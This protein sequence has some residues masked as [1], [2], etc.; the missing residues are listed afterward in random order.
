MYFFCLGHRHCEI[1]KFT[2]LSFR[3]ISTNYNSYTQRNNN[4]IEK[5]TQ[6]N[7]KIFFISSLLQIF[8]FFIQYDDG[9]LSMTKQ[10]ILSPVIVIN[11]NYIIIYTLSF[12]S[13]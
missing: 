5:K 2:I 1:T 3:N 13:L 9:I 6:N 8:I 4:K 12:S 10:T 11:Y 7:E